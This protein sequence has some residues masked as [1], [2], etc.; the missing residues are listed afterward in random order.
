[1]KILQDNPKYKI[2]VFVK[3]CKQCTLIC[4]TLKALDFQATQLHSFMKNNRRIANLAMF[5]GDV[6]NILVT[7]DLTS[8]GLDINSVN[9]V[10]NYNMPRTV[11]DYIHRV[12]R[13]ARNGYQGQAITLLTPN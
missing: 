4:Q 9:L 1:M 3:T 8:R 11:A 12:G 2:I 7:T 6:S 10:I 5:R 13:T